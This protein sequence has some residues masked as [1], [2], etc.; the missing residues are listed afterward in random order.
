MAHFLIFFQLMDLF[1]RLIGEATCPSYLRCPLLACALQLAS[2]CLPLQYKGFL[3]LCTHA[4]LT[5]FVD[6]LSNHFIKCVPMS[7]TCL[8]CDYQLFESENPK[9]KLEHL[10]QGTNLTESTKNE[11][12][13]LKNQLKGLEPY[14]VVFFFFLPN[15]QKAKS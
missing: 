1:L 15:C 10:G 14:G 8:T 5:L 4:L 2:I 7:P 12:Q 6:H 13:P 3:H 9:S 11:T